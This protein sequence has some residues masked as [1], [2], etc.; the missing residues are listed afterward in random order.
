MELKKFTT[1]ICTECGDEIES[2]LMNAVNHSRDCR[3]DAPNEDIEVH[4]FITKSNEIKKKK[5]KMFKPIWKKMTYKEQIQLT[6][7]SMCG[8]YIQR[9]MVLM[10]SQ[11]FNRFCNYESKMIKQYSIKQ[12]GKWSIY[13]KTDKIVTLHKK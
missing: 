6:V 13:N 11:A 1:D 8:S 5:E 10:G 3:Y 12:Y 4:R 7:L 9:N 2:G